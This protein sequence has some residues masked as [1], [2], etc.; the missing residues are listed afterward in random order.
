MSKSQ[1]VYNISNEEYHT[2]E[3]ISRSGIMEFKITPFH[4]WN[5]YLNPERPEKKPPTPAMV[6]G[7]ILH[8]YILEPGTFDDRYIVAEKVDKR[9]KFGISYHQTLHEEKG[10]REII[11]KDIFLEIKKIAEALWKNEL[12]K[13]LI[14]GAQFE[15]SFYWTD[16]DSGILCKARP[17]IW[18]SNMICDLKS[19]DSA[20]PRDFQNALYKYGFH[21]QA[22]MINQAI[23]HVYKKD[24]R[25]FIYITVEK[26]FPYAHALYK[27][28]EIALE[29][30][31]ADYKNKLLQLR[32]CMET[33]TW[34]SY[35]TQI[36]TLPAYAY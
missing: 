30:G 13:A 18:H 28:D 25:E 5:A 7:T 35:P 15:Q 24:I 3:G 22:A 32:D 11:A 14:T 17:D 1:G 36:I 34:P 6:F 4:Y 9:T 21:I 33:N 23:K 8:N 16:P 27:L 20:S 29:H 12:A 10:I 31:I 19:T 26:D 2:G